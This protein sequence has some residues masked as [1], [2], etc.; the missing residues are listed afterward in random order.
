MKLDYSKIKSLQNRHELSDR[1]MAKRIGMSNTGYSKMMAKESCT[2]KTLV[3]I[4]EAFQKPLYYFFEVENRN[5]TDEAQITLYSCPDC[6]KREKQ[7]KEQNEKID[8]LENELDLHK[9]IIRSQQETI[10]AYKDKK[11]NHSET[12]T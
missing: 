1:E 5:Q 10:D 4:S 3:N 2:V 9:K 6:D 8:R 12:G 11:G 7:I